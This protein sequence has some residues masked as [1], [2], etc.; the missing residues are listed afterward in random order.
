MPKCHW[1]PFLV[2]CICGSRSPLLFL[3]ELGAAIRVASTT[4]PVLSIKPF[5]VRVTLMAAMIWMLSWLSSSKWRGLGVLPNRR[6]VD[7]SGKRIIPGSRRANSRS[8]EKFHARLLPS[9][10]QTDQT[11]VKGSGYATWSQPETPVVRLGCRHRWAQTAESKPPARSMA[12]PNS[13]RQETS[14]CVYAW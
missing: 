4:V 1:L 6:M 12:P 10:D 14:V 2:W 11:I 8:T 3:V 7:S 9:Q 5:L 13:S